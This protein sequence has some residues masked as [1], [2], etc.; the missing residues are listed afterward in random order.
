MRKV[1]LEIEQCHL[2]IH[3]FQLTLEQ[4]HLEFGLREMEKDLR[5]VKTEQLLN[6]LS[7]FLLFW[8][9][10]Q[11]PLGLFRCFLKRGL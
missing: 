10:F 5:L 3:H 2:G 11:D 1:Y 8:R 9:Q 4:F 6:D 7:Y